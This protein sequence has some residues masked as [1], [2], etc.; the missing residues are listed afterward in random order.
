MKNR[1]MNSENTPQAAAA[2]LKKLSRLRPSLAIVLGSGFHHAATHLRV[3]KEVP[4]TKIPGFPQPTVQGHA[5]K[6]FFGELGNTPVVILSGRAHYYEGHSMEH[7]TFAVRALA[8]FGIHDLLLTNAAGGINKSFHAGDLMAITDHINFMGVSP[9]RGSSNF[10]DMTHVYDPKLNKLL[11]EAAGECKIKLRRGVY[12]A[13]CGPNYETP[14]EIRAFAKLG[15]DAIGMSTVPEA[16]VARQWGVNVAGISCITNLAA[17]RSKKVLSHL[18]VLEVGERANE[19]GA[20]LLK[21]FASLYGRR[22]EH[23][24][25][26]SI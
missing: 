24:N 15:A 2:A 19:R 22:M 14:S 20:A 10:V 9:L 7:V 4:F 5:G 6:L 25:W 17:G 23:I 26:P 18:E 3:E 11:V 21:N 1:K 12:M 16:I 13:V 8:A